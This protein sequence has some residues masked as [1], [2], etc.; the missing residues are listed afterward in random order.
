MKFTHVPPGQ[1]VEVAL[2]K[3][4]VAVPT[5]TPAM[6][7]G[8]E[9][10]SKDVEAA[11]DAFSLGNFCLEAGKTKEAIEA[12]EKVVKLDPSYAEAWSK[13]SEAYLKAGNKAKS[14]QA[15]QK[16]KALTLR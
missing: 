13:L 2:A 9:L 7:Q 16:Y 10:P 1:S 5:P 8:G 14:D 11:V 3:K 4:A 15:L 6:V 12:F